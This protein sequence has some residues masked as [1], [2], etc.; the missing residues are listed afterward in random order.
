[1]A[2]GS[3]HPLDEELARIG[4]DGPPA[5]RVQ[6]ACRAYAAAT[7]RQVSWPLTE[8]QSAAV[9]EWLINET[10]YAPVAIPWHRRPVLQPAVHADV[11]AKAGWLQQAPCIQCR[12]IPPAGKPPLPMSFAVPVRPFTKQVKRTGAVLTGAI[13]KALQDRPPEAVQPAEVWRDVAIC[14][15]IVAIQAGPA[16]IIDVDNAAKAILDTMKN[17]VFPDDR[18]VE[19]LSVSRLRHPGSTAYYLISL[20]PVY[21]ALDDVIDPRRQ[22]RFAGLVPPI[23]G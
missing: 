9:R 11:A 8:V 21:P 19:H 16:R 5:E 22:V 10:L 18:Q 7:G 15:S 20:R 23:S 17:I 13:R 4:P 1:M 12:I 6:A 3:K 14:A 2:T